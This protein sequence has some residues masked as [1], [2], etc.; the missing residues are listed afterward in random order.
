MT[1]SIHERISTSTSE[2]GHVND[3]R[4]AKRL[5]VVRPRYVPLLHR[6]REHPVDLLT[7][8]EQVTDCLDALFHGAHI[9]HG[10]ISVNSIVWSPSESASSEGNF[11]LCDLDTA[12]DLDQDGSATVHVATTP[13]WHRTGTLPFLAIELIKGP[14]TPHRLHHNY[15]SL[16]WVVLWCAMKADYHAAGTDRAVIDKSLNKWESIRP[17]DI[18]SEKTK[19]L[20]MTWEE[21]PIPKRFKESSH[22]SDFVDNFRTFIHEAPGKVNTVL[23]KQR[24]RSGIAVQ[25]RSEI[26]DTIV[27]KERIRAMLKEAAELA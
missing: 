1:G 27:C 2:L 12:L 16:F 7:M 8:V 6:I 24:S 10:D 17:R 21:L 5:R 11:V 4:V 20:A 26:L 18:V 22:I 14:E 15:E 13:R 19:V 9:L 25:D 3:A 23:R